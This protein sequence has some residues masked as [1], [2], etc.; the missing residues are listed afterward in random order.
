VSFQGPEE[1]KGFRG[2]V[3]EIQAP[4]SEREEYMNLSESSTVPYRLGLDINAIQCR[5][6]GL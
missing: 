6:K 2:F 5:S 1:T 3:L 4:E